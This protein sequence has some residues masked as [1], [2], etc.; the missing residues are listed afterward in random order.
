MNTYKFYKKLL[1]WY[2]KC[3]VKVMFKLL[4][5]LLFFFSFIN[6]AKAIPA[7]AILLGY[8]F[9]IFLSPF[10]LLVFSFIYFFFKK[11][12]LLISILLLLLSIFLYCSH[13]FI[14]KEFILFRYEYVFLFFYLFFLYTSYKFKFFYFFRYIL[15]FILLLCLSLFLKLNYNLFKFYLISNCVENSINYDNVI[16]KSNYYKDNFIA[17]YWYDNNLKVSWYSVL[18]IWLFYTDYYLNKWDYF[19][20]HWWNIWLWKY[21]S[22]LSYGCIE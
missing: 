1:I 2:F 3:F 5:L 20:V 9:F 13:Y 22:D 10:I 11:H 21:L 7:P 4:I 18:Q 14:T 19:I 17:I 15:F 12:F 6:V 8:D 16:I